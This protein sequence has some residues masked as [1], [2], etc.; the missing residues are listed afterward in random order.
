MIATL[1]SVFRAATEQGEALVRS[2][3]QAARSQRTR[4]AAAENAGASRQVAGVGCSV[5]ELYAFERMPGLERRPSSVVPPPSRAAV[6]G[7]ADR[8]TSDQLSRSAS[9][10]V[11]TS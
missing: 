3:P 10:R 9:P 11:R 6:H 2:N 5:G 4:V 8:G 7:D 1:D